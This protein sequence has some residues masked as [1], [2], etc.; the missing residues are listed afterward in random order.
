MA[1]E[2]KHENRLV[3]SWRLLTAAGL[4]SEFRRCREVETSEIGDIQRFAT[5]EQFRHTFGW[6]QVRHPSLPTADFEFFQRPTEPAELCISIKESGA[7]ALGLQL[8]GWSIDGTA[9]G[10]I[11]G[12]GSTVFSI[13]SNGDRL[14]SRFPD[15]EAFFEHLAAKILADHAQL[16]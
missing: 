2:Q 4:T 6:G 14:R 15:F 8:F 7:G 3:A 10:H 11:G 1:D 13:S 9:F 16:G 12:R 5:F